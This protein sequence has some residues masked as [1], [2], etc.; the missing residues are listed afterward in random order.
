MILNVRRKSLIEVLSRIG[1]VR[2]YKVYKD[3]QTMLISTFNSVVQVVASH[4]NGRTIVNMNCLFS[5]RN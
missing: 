3:R 5:L 2:I 1:F 4:F